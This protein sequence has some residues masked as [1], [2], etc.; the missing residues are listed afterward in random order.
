MK[1]KFSTLT[2]EQLIMIQQ[3]TDPVKAELAK[4]ELV[5][6]QEW[7]KFKRSFFFPNL[8]AVLSLFLSA[9]LALQNSGLID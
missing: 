5:R 9:Y 3:S 4:M 8:W 2:A 7:T 6:R 1:N